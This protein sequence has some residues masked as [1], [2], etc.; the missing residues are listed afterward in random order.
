MSN[1][2]PMSSWK[3]YALLV[4]GS[5]IE[6]ALDTILLYILNKVYE[7]NVYRLR[8]VLQFVSHSYKGVQACLHR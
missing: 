3:S 2:I 4:E 1:V 8:A 7:M 6:S 5:E